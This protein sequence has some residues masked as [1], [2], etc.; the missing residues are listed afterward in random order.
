MSYLSYEHIKEIERSRIRNFLRKENQYERIKR[1]ND[2]LSKRLFQIS[3][4]TT[5]DDKNFQYEKNLDMFNSKRLQQRLNEYKHI[6]NENHHLI[7]HINNVRGQLINKQECD[8]D[9][10]RNINIMKKTC[11]YPDNID[12]FVSNK[13]INQQ[14]KMCK[15]ND[16]FQFKKKK[17]IYCNS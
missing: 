10:Q 13:N 3:K 11:H 2:L 17:I 12:R 16:R 4:R 14:R 15:W 9:W 8:Q 1:E 7:K 6:N 5:L